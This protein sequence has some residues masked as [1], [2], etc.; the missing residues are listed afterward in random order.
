MKSLEAGESWHADPQS[1]VGKA[2]VVGEAT[3]RWTSRATAVRIQASREGLA[4]ITS[5]RAISQQG[6]VAT[7][8]DPLTEGEPKVAGGMWSGA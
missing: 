7:C 6:L 8:K 2:D 4:E 3:V 1:P 5:G